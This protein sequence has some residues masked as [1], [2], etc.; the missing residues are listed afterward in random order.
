MLDKLMA[1]VAQLYP[2]GRAFKMVVDGYKEAMHRAIA[3]QKA[4]LIADIQ[5]TFDS[6]LPDNANFTT[7]DATAWERRLGLITNTDVTL[8]DRK[9][10]IQRKMNYPGKQPARSHWQ[11]I[12]SQLQLAG[13]GV[14][15]HENRFSDGMGGYVTK[16]PLEL[17]ADTGNQHGLY[18]MGDE[19]HEDIYPP[20][21]FELIYNQHGDI[22]L[23]DVQH[24]QYYVY[25]PKIANHVTAA[26]DLTFQIGTL[27]STFFIGGVTA[28]SFASVPASREREFRELVL[29]FK[30]LNTVALLF[31]NYV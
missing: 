10:A 2:T 26:D 16:T 19:Q 1:L 31:I 13:F 27:R 14:Y 21:L 7:A 9:A 12:Q 8:P 30:P 6:A 11:F 15:I 28:G 5:S 3:T 18:Q 25:K 20:A 29:K 24:G 22:Q 4:V 17:L 23:G